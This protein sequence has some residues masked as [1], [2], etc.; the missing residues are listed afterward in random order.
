MPNHG[1]GKRMFCFVGL[2]LCQTL[3]LD[4]TRTLRRWLEP[5]DAYSP[6]EYIKPPGSLRSAA[7]VEI[8]GQ[9][10]GGM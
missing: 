1:Q 4:A 8:R 7:T 9:P 5:L 2:Y 3:I 6:G 10:K